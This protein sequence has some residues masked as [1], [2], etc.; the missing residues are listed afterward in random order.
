MT[1]RRIAVIPIHDEAATLAAV[2]EDVD[3]Q[4]D[5]FIL[6]DDGSK[7]GSAD[8]ARELQ[9]RR[10]GVWFL[11]HPGNRGMA[12]ALK[13]GF[14]FAARMLEEGLLQPDDIVINIDADGQH[15]VYEIPRAAAR[16][17]ADGLDLLLVVRDFS[18][19]P[20]YKVLGNR[21]LTALARAVSGFPYRDVE[22]GFRFLRVRCL[23]LLLPYFT[24]WRYSCA[25]EIAIIT[26]L[27]GGLR[28]AN[29][30]LVRINYYRPGTTL[31][32]GFAVLVMSLFSWLRV[33]I[34]W[35]SSPE[36]A[37][38]HLADVIIE[39]P[40]TLLAGRS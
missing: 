12:Q 6:V 7:N 3:P 26:S 9:R 2:L 11:R 8:I 1:S 24:G 23:P 10:P 40:P 16:M 36:D 34:S 35:R 37:R 30:H 20:R 18:L 27:L 32:D 22:S 17:D 39:S 21:L 31:M 38:R 19:Y 4:V 25:Q 33:R 5:F 15:P 29:D 28:I 14:C 13:T